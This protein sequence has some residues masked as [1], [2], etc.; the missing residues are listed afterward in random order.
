MRKSFIIGIASV[1]SILLIV[2]LLNI[3]SEPIV[4]IED[5]QSIISMT[6][7]GQQF[8]DEMVVDEIIN[9]LEQFDVVETGNPFPMETTKTDININ[10]TDNHKPRHIVLGE[11]N[12]LYESADDTIYK[13]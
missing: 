9:L 2:I 11:V 4:M 10:Y 8:T 3:K 12:I 13:I 5:G 1:T 7:N 6:I